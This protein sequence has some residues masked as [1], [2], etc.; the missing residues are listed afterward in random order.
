LEQGSKQ[1]G[2]LGKSCMPEGASGNVAVITLLSDSI[3][4]ISALQEIHSKAGMGRQYVV[5]VITGSKRWK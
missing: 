2:I 1:F 3:S 5:L 4:M